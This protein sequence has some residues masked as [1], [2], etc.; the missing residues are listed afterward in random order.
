MVTEI[1]NPEVKLSLT[2][3]G[4]DALPDKV[5]TIILDEIVYTYKLNEFFE[6]LG[7]K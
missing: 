3:Q 4:I 1:Y 2:S 6:R 7:I 5:I